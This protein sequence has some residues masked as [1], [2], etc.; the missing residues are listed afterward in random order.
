MVSAI[1]IYIITKNNTLRG[2]LSML[3]PDDRDS[4]VINKEYVLQ[5][6]NYGIHAESIGIPLG[7]IILNASIKCHSKDD[8][9]I[10]L[11]NLKSLISSNL[12]KVYEGSWVG[13]HSCNQVEDGKQDT[14]CTL[15]K[16]WSN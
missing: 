13:I 1:D 5:V 12:A 2:D 10:V 14:P 6:I 16:I 15:Q 8:V 11:N 4:R 3:L 7:A 9:S